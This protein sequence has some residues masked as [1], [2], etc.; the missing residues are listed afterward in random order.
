M[1]WRWPGLHAR[2]SS[3]GKRLTLFGDTGDDA[4]PDRA[5][6][7]NDVVFLIDYR[8]VCA[9]EVLGELSLVVAGDDEYGILFIDNSRAE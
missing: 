3:S 5:M 9:M 1:P 7:K 2:I 6:G 8:A 4:M